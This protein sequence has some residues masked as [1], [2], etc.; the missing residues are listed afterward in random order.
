MYVHT[1]NYAETAQANTCTVET[2][3]EGLKGQETLQAWSQYTLAGASGH[4]LS[5]RFFREALE[6]P[7]IFIKSYDINFVELK[8]IGFLGTCARKWHGQTQTWWRCSNAREQ[9]SRGVP[10]EAAVPCASVAP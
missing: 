7:Y 6:S 2:L 3:D 8:T 4:N 9:C 10:Y 1:P 5:P